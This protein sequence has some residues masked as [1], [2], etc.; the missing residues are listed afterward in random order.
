MDL[1]SRVSA[2]LF[3]WVVCLLMV[4]LRVTAGWRGRKA[5]AMAVAGRRVLGRK[6]G[7]SLRKSL[8]EALGHRIESPTAPV[9]VRE[10]LAFSPSDLEHALAELKN[11]PGVVEG[12]ILSTCNRVEVAVDRRRHHRSPGSSKHFLAESR[13]LDRQG[14]QQ[15]LYGFEGRDAIRHIF[16]VAASLDSMVVGEPQILGQLKSAYSVA[17]DHG[18]R[19]RTARHGNHARIRSRKTGPHRNRHRCQRGFHQL[20]CRR[21]CARDLRLAETAASDAD[22]RRQDVR[23]GSSPSVAFGRTADS[24]DESNRSSRERSSELVRGTIVPYE[25]YRTG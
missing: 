7:S 9:S 5:A 13:R 20:C 25:Q 3:N 16:R 22:R 24:G 11:R 6:L 10:R 17:K 15:Y 1:R 2:C 4:F 23:T 21:A 8:D 18:S 19:Q 12:M 14:I